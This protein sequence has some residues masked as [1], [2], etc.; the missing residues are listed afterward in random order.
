MVSVLFF[1]QVEK[2]F[3]YLVDE[4]GFSVVEKKQHDS[5]DNAKVVLRSEECCI[6]VTREKGYVEVGAGPSSE[7]IWYD[8][9]TLVAYLTEG[10]EELQYDV[11]DYDDDFDYDARIEW[12]LKKLASI[13]PKYLGRICELFR[14]DNFDRKRAELKD[15][16]RSRFEK[17]ATQLMRKADKADPG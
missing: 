11:P 3:H 16:L 17:W 2:Y 15:F 13:L 4:Y 6:R 1:N 5:F 10:D 14:G 9:P 7:E 8:L 12:Q